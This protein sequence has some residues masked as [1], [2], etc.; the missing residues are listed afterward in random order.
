VDLL[1]PAFAGIWSFYILG[2]GGMIA[3][4]TEATTASIVVQA[5]SLRSSELWPSAREVRLEAAVPAFAGMTT[6]APAVSTFAKQHTLLHLRNETTLKAP[7]K[8]SA[9]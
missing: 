3:T 1:V 9:W 8:P 2:A 5:S 7:S 6:P 4:Q